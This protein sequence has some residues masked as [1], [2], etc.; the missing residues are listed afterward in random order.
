MLVGTED[1]IQR[2]TVFMASPLQLIHEAMVMQESGECVVVVS[3]S[4]RACPLV[5]LGWCLL[6]HHYRRFLF[7]EKKAPKG[8]L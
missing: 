5:L 1:Q 2:P 6:P 7:V 3:S 4:G 8:L